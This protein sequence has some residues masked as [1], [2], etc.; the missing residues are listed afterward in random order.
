[1]T[2]LMSLRVVL[3]VAAFV[4][5]LITIGQISLASAAQLDVNQSGVSTFTANA[6]TD[7][8]IG[9]T[10]S[11]SSSS[12]TQL[13]V[14]GVPTECTGTLGT[15]VVVDAAGTALA[16]ATW[17]KTA[18][19]NTVSTSSFDTSLV[20]SVLLLADGWWIDTTWT[21]PAT[22]APVYCTSIDAQGLPTGAECSVT[23]VDDVDW[24]NPGT[25]RGWAKYD[26][27]TTSENA[28]FVIDLAETPFPDWTPTAARTN[29]DWIAAPGYSCDEWPIVRLYAN[30]N[31][32]GVS[33]EVYIEVVEK[34]VAIGTANRICPN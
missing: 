19:T 22:S 7:Q 13:Q 28:I 11:Q 20:S 1:M 24:G 12:Q 29:G 32:G 27:D 8:V 33:T 2:R 16:Q 34:Q 9:I 25:R 23:E 15:I 30:P 17:T 10:A 4:V 21:A 31:K 3:A 26:V 6:C 5:A 18:G 14:T